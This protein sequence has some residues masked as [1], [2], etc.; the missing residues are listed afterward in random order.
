MRAFWVAL[1]SNSKIIENGPDFRVLGSNSGKAGGYGTVKASLR[2]VSS[3]QIRSGNITL[4]ANATT[5]F[6]DD[7]VVHR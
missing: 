1:S 6:L 2:A 7:E 5:A 4:S 3:R